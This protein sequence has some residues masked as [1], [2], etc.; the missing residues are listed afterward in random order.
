MEDWAEIRRLHR[1]A[2]VPIKEIARR[3]GVPVTRCGPR[4]SPT[5]R[6]NRRAPRVTYEPGQL[7]QCD[8]WFPE[9]RIPVVPGRQRM[10]PV[11]VMTLAFSRFMTVTMIP[12]RQ[13]GDILSGMWT[14]IC[15]VGRVTKFKGMV[16][17]HNG[18]LET[19]FLPGRRLPHRS[20]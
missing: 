6:R 5:G 19:S 8:L 18:Y 15:Q 2:G 3:L 11:L 7:T 14:L 1:A 9:P 13:A 10:L 20:A 17:R 4:C 16:E 12:S